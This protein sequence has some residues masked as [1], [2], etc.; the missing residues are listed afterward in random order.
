MP[1]YSVLYLPVSAGELLTLQNSETKRYNGR[2]PSPLASND[3]YLL[4]E[5]HLAMND[6]LVVLHWH[7]LG[8]RPQ[9]TVID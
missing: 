7:L 2:H 3:T 6:L 5:V 9:G 1:I 4:L 8:G